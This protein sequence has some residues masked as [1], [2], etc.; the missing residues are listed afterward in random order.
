MEV[1]FRSYNSAKMFTD[2]NQLRDC[3]IIRFIY[4]IKNA[5]NNLNNFFVKNTKLFLYEYL[6][7]K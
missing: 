5:K 2:R 4:F 1:R 6:N 7:I 3:R